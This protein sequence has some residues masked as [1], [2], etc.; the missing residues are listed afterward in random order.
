[1]SWRLFLAAGFAL[2]LAG[3]ANGAPPAPVRLE[4]VWRADGLAQPESVAPSA[5]GRTLYVSNVGG[6][7][8]ARDGVGFISRLSPDGRVLQREWVTG[9]NAPK[10]IA[11]AGDTLFVADIDAIVEIDAKRGAIARRIAVD[12]AR[13]LNDAARAPDGAVLVSDSGGAR[14]YALRDGVASVW[15]ADEQLSA[16][17]GL[18][19]ERDR[20]VVT[21]MAGKLLA[22]DWKTK[23]ITVLATG[24][25]DG[26]GVAPLGRGR[27]LA[28]EW[29]G[30]IF[31]IDAAGKATVLLDTRGAG[32]LQN[33]FA[34]VGDTLLVANWEPGAVTAWRVRR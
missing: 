14:I 12:G 34:L 25:G 1:M 2:L 21:T 5:D 24:I 3:C 31:E 9:L 10:G 16:V 32:I 23:A 30:R 18:L 17:N 22:V 28:S 6:E 33:D 13:F 4:Q 11:V 8:D 27:Y 20:L 15:L 7:A 26:D 29:R 19:P